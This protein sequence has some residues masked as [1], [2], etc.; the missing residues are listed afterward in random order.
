M[1][2]NSA[3]PW[4]MAQRERRRAVV[5]RAG[6]QG[7]RVAGGR[8]AGSGSVAVKPDC[9]MTIVP[10]AGASSHLYPAEC[11]LTPADLGNSP[12]VPSVP[13]RAADPATGRSTGTIGDAAS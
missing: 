1:A 11:R 12:E 13:P 10:R 5:R 8:G 3:Y 2:P 7:R 6:Q 9:Q 4:V